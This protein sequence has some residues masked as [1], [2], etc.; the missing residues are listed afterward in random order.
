MVQL[1]KP[2]QVAAVVVYIICGLFSSNFV[3][4]YVIVVVLLML[5]C[6]TVGSCSTFKLACQ[7]D[8]SWGLGPST[9]W[10]QPF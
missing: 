10:F 2:V 1:R 4:N 8:T 6:W 3:A 5:D 7:A 9:R